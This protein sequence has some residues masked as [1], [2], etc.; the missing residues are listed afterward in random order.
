MVAQ[1]FGPD[2]IAIGHERHGELVGVVAFDH[3]SEH[4]CMFHAASNGSK[5]WITR[6]FI[7]RAMAYPFRQCNF[8]RMTCTV[9]ASNVESLN[10]CDHFGWTPEGRLREEGPF[11]E[12]MIVFGLLRR[13]CGWVFGSGKT[14]PRRL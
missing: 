11:G 7:R 3:F 8:R 5:R 14:M 4:S 9:A 2:A 12:D 1:T 13:E 10:F 6:E